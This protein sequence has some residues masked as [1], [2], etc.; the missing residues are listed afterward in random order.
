MRKKRAVPEPAVEL[1]Y[2][3]TQYREAVNAADEARSRFAALVRVDLG[4]RSEAEIVVAGKTVVLIRTL[5]KAEGYLLRT[6][7]LSITQA[8]MLR[9]FLCKTLGP[10]TKEETE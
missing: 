6:V 7:G 10:P 4:D 2:K 5:G 3:L 1:S 8:A 9:D